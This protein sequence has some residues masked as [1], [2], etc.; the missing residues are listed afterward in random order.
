ML[1][2]P[3]V[4]GDLEVL[5]TSPAMHYTE[6]MHMPQ[7]LSAAWQTKSEKKAVFLVNTAEEEGTYK[8][9]FD[10]TNFQEGIISPHEIKV[11]EM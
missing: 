10:E 2:P 4:E 7:L 11:W 6:E 9:Y 8:I 5:K 1:R 3:K